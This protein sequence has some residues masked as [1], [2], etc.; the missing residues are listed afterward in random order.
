MQS[1]KEVGRPGENNPANWELMNCSQQARQ[2]WGPAG[3]RSE[4]NTGFMEEVEPI[5]EVN[6]KKIH[7]REFGPLG[8]S[9]L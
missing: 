2:P 1:G 8:H 4:E 3:F 9:D 7:T 5:I 6:M